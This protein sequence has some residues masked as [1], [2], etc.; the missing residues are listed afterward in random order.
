[1]LK[2]IG[3]QER[4]FNELKLLTDTTFQFSPEKTA[5]DMVEEL[6]VCMQYFP[7]SDYITGNTL[8][9]EYDEEVSSYTRFDE[10]FFV[11]IFFSK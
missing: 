9:Y 8:F 5:A 10:I 6:S 7:P 3:P 1:M 2:R 4:I 11:T